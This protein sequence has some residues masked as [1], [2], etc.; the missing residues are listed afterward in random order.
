MSITSDKKDR[1]MD[2]LVKPVQKL[3]PRKTIGLEEEIAEAGRLFLLL[4]N[5]EL[6]RQQLK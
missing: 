3:K 4:E 5:P 1:G 2:H 6:L